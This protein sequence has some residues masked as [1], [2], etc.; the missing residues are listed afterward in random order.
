MNITGQNMKRNYKGLYVVWLISTFVVFYL[1]NTHYKICAQNYP[2]DAANYWEL[3][4]SLFSS[5]HF[6]LYTLQDD[7]RGYVFP[8][9]MGICYRL[10]GGGKE[11]NYIWLIYSILLVG[12]FIPYSRFTKMFESQNVK[13]R[14]MDILRYF[15]PVVM[16]CF[17]FYGLIIYPLTDLYAALL[18]I[19]GVYFVYKAFRMDKLVYKFLFLTMAGVILY[20]TY[21]IRTIYM[22]T[23]FFIVLVIVIMNFKVSQGNA[24]NKIAQMFMSVLCY[25]GGTAVGAIPQLL[26]NYNKYG[27]ISP[28]INT[29]N[30]FAK[31]LFWGLNF[32]RYATYTGNLQECNP[33]MFFIDRTGVKIIAK[34]SEL[35]FAESIKSYICL[36]IKYP[37]DFISIFGKHIV[38]SFFILFPEQYVQHLY[39]NRSIYA[40]LS[41]AVVFMI[42]I[43][44]HSNHKQIFAQGNGLYILAML[45]PS[46]AI[47]FGAV[48]ER[49]MVL[50]YLLGYGLLAR[51]DYKEWVSTLTKKRI[52]RLILAFII[53]AVFALAVESE[54]LGSLQDAPLTFTGLK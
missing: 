43:A 49:F 3:G 47:L 42:F 27:I 14:S 4:A 23:L 34:Q 17:F 24:I 22:L 37:T 13:N 6:S 18:C 50:P 12:L 46:I 2:Y 53:F 28:M 1:I 11:Y 31:Q 54:I 38:N 33:G 16:V 10:S 19:S 32:S 52:I 8:V 21:N 41:L 45:L 20:L 5:G 40:L 48:E 36:F 29:E 26:I 15:V 51:F 39:I 9:F 7:F 44:I 35:S 25:L 30:L